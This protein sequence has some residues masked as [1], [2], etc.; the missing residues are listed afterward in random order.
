M[1]KS[2]SFLWKLTGGKPEWI[3]LALLYIAS[4]MHN[5]LGDDCLRCFFRKGILRK[6]CLAHTCQTIIPLTWTC[7]KCLLDDVLTSESQSTLHLQIMLWA[8]IF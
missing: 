6:L 5:D 8:T 4:L 7:K 2:T 1:S 3:L